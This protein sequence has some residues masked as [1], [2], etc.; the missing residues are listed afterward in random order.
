M[1]GFIMGEVMF[2]S[3]QYVKTFLQGASQRFSTLMAKSNLKIISP[4]G[5]QHALAA[6]P[7]T[8]QQQV[9]DKL[10]IFM[11]E[12]KP[13]LEHHI[14]VERLAIKIGVSPK[15]LSSSI[16]GELNKNFFELIND[17]RIKEV[18][19]QLIHRDNENKTI[20]EIMKSCGF[21]SKSVFNQAF[22]K[23]VGSTPSLYRLQKQV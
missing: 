9:I 13:Y 18:K 15:L 12:E 2:F 23:N 7:L 8:P 5:R 6:T 16:N 10:L 1:G 19:Q 14:T 22:K 3:A 20:H 17:Y 21:S 4:S 11:E